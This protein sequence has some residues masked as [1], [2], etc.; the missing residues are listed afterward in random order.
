VS[1][2]HTPPVIADKPQSLL[3]GIR[4]VGAVK[5]T[6]HGSAIVHEHR[7]ARGITAFLDRE[8]PAIRCANGAFHA[9]SMRLGDL[10]TRTASRRAS[11]NGPANVPNEASTAEMIS[12]RSVVLR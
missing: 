7:A 5:V 4:R 11:E 1:S 9:S 10:R 2:R 8:D 6:R 3:G 12:A